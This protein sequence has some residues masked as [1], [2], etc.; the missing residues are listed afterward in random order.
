MMS[1]RGCH[2]EGAVLT[3]GVSLRI[4]HVVLRPS[5]FIRS[6]T[7]SPSE[8]AAGMDPGRTDVI[9]VV[10]PLQYGTLK[11]AKFSAGK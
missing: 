5:H 7:A 4:R 1:P 11:R 2:C 9:L 8:R 10:E 3:H 6:S